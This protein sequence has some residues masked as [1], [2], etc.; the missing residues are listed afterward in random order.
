MDP[1]HFVKMHGAR[2]D[3]IVLDRRQSPIEDAPGL[4][5]RL[6]ER[7]SG[8]G[9]DGLLVVDSSRVAQAAMRIFN[10]DG[11]EAEMCGNGIRCVARYLD[12][13]GEGA[14][15]GIETLAGVI[16]TRVVER[17]P[18]F[19]VRVTL[20]VPTYA[21]LDESLARDAHFVLMGNPHVVLLRSSIDESELVATALA[22]QGS[23]ALPAGGNVH[24][25]V[26]EGENAMR[27]AHWERGVGTTQACGTGAVSCAVTAIV[28][29]LARSPVLV[30]VPGG[31]ITVEWD[32]SGAAHMTGP[33]ERIFE[34]DIAI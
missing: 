32:G 15:L 10:A 1:I 24:V 7:R 20:G 17:E 16:Q 9:A 26:V 25:A 23:S 14:A 2:N 11:S 21:R 29:G 4:A 3:F 34:T 31:V 22:L 19:R 6:C 18:A 30:R 5:R 33:A 28:L 13:R 12:E 27:A 8:I